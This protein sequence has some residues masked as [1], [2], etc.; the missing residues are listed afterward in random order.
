M[1][2]PRVVS[3]YKLSTLLGTGNYGEVR[4]A[5]HVDTNELYAIKILSRDFLQFNEYSIDVRREMVSFLASLFAFF[6][7]TILLLILTPFF[8]V[9]SPGDATSK[10]NKDA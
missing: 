5:E 3:N 8:T 6:Y 1:N 7:S 9:N 4:L 10:H 2:Y